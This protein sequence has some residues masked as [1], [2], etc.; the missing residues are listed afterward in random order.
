MGGRAPEREVQ[1][2]RA[3][4]A[5][6]VLGEPGARGQIQVARVGPDGEHMGH[7]DRLITWKRLVTS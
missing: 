5:Q 2:R 1:Q 4:A 7:A 6:D 3:V